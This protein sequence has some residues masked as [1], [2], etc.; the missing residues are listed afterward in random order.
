ME[1][2][3][4][5]LP[6]SEPEGRVDI[7][8]TNGTVNSVQLTEAPFSEPPSLLLPSL[9]HPHI[10]L[11]KPYILTCNHGLKS[12]SCI[13]P[14]KDVHYPDYSDL[15]P[16]SGDF[17]EALRNTSLAKER[18]TPD[19]LYIRGGQLLATAYRQG[20]T[21]TRAF[22]EVDHVVGL[23]A[24][25]AGVKLK[26]DFAHLLEVQLC[27]FAQDPI[28][29]G[30]HGTEN[31]DLVLEALQSYG[32]SIDVLGTTPYV[33]KSRDTAVENIKWAIETALARNLHLDFHIDY[34]LDRD[35]SPDELLTRIVVDE[36]IRKDWPAV[37]GA[38]KTIVL[39]HATRLTV[40]DQK[41]L[42]SLADDILVHKLPVHFV[43]LPT[44]DIFMMGR[45]SNADGSLER[46][47]GTLPVPTLIKQGLNACLGVNNVGNAFT[48]YGTG[49]PLSLASWGVGLYQ[50]GTVDD[51]DL[52]YS[53]VSWRARR[54]I[55]LE[56]G[57]E[58]QP[59][60][61]GARWQPVLLVRNKSLIDIPAA[62]SDADSFGS[63][64]AGQA[65]K[66][67]AR[68]RLSI[69]DVV[70]DPPELELRRSVR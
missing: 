53:C 62:S 8:V 65:L 12:S 44:S 20:V 50:A 32:E 60:K 42:Q 38:G 55:G 9:C 67:P 17:Q 4:V 2:T 46:P 39:G 36:L 61:E 47:R 45:A 40:L 16:T 68:Q 34:D 29:S 41:A 24:L 49:D 7:T 63:L 30:D 5:I 19:D 27:V 25:E 26:N 37:A 28:F 48:P 70:W 59:F 3:N 69:K 22:V 15:A 10:H 57:D 23:Q 1:L 56:Q 21:H 31:R 14:Q 66:I 35:R 58:T 18:Y 6:S 33:E 51:A 64:E 13:F 54:A 52:L 11:D 43:G